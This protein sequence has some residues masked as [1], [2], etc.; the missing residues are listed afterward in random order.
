MINGGFSTFLAVVLLALS[1]SAGFRVL[2]KMFFGIVVFGESALFVYCQRLKLDAGLFIGIVV[3]PV[4]LS[5][6]I[7]CSSERTLS[8]HVSLF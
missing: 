7:R 8:I 3:L 2:F 1:Q 6:I 5:V 4:V